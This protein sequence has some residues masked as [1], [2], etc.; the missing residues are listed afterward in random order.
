MIRKFLVLALVAMLTFSTSAQVKTKSCSSGQ[1][2]ATSWSDDFNRASLGTNWTVN[3]GGSIYSSTEFQFTAGLGIE[4]AFY[5]AVT[6]TDNQFAQTKLS[7]LSTNA[8]KMGPAVR[9]NSAGNT[10]YTLRCYATICEFYKFVSGATGTGSLPS[11]GG[12]TPTL[13]DTVRLEVT[14]SNPVVLHAYKCTDGAA[15]TSKVNLGTAGYTY[16]DSD[17]DRIVSGSAGIHGNYIETAA[18]N[19]GRIDDWKGGN[20]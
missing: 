19:N 17:A 10:F 5:N 11:I 9:I 8:N 18:G 6:F 3:G 7:N 13:G 14:G 1:G 20:L 15:C 2:A 16:S 12:Y 4:Y